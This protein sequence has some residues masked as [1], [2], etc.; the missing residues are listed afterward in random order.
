MA[1]IGGHITNFPTIKYRNVKLYD[2]STEFLQ[3][4]LRTNSFMKC[5][6]SD[7]G[8]AYYTSLDNHQKIVEF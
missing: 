6:F 2:L 4:I 1:K 3:L 8:N 5:W 7:P